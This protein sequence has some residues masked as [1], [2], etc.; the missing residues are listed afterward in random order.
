LSDS[1][2]EASDEGDG[3][4]DFNS[5]SAEANLNN[6]SLDGPSPNI[7]NKSRIYQSNND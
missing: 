3:E 6:N 5:M 7:I 1:E 2:K 4:K